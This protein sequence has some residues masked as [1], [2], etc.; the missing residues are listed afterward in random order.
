MATMTSVDQG[1]VTIPATS[2]RLIDGELNVV[3]ASIG[4]NYKGTL[5]ADSIVGFLMQGGTRH[6]V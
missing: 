6:S 1:N 4:F 3:I 5:I 2:V